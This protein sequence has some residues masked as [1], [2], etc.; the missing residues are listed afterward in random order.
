MPADL[1]NSAVAT[2]LEKV[3]FYS[4]LKERQ[5]QRM[6]QLLDNYTHLMEKA[7][8]THS[9]TLA[10][11]IPWTKEPGGLQSMG[12]LRVGHDW[13]TFAQK[14]KGFRVINEAED[15][16][17]EFSCFFYDPTDVG[18]LISGSSAFSKSTW[19][20][21][22]SPFMY[23]WSLA[24]RI[25]SN[26]LLAVW[27]EC[28]CAYVWTFFGIALLWDWNENWPFPVLWSMLN[29]PNLLANWVQHFNSIIF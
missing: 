15:V 14:V 17:L 13:A 23:C 16:F 2:G 11:K 3:R 26:T 6:L 29:F 18:N 4:N 22:S 12:S 24:W 28:N 7:M 27:N 25:W 20:S 8:A 21:G 10:W 19:T 5:C 9:S 1:E